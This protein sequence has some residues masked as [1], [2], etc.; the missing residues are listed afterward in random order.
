[1]SKNK[2]FIIPVIVIV[3]ICAAILCIVL[4]PSKTTQTN[5]HSPEAAVSSSVAESSPPASA[6]NAPVEYKENKIEYEYYDAVS[7][8][9]QV[10][11]VTVDE[12][13]GLKKGLELVAE[14]LFGKPLEETP[15]DPNSIVMEGDSIK[16]D[17]KTTIA[18]SALGASEEVAMLN[19]I[20]NIYLNNIDGVN[21]IYF[22]IAGEDFITG[23]MVQRKDTPY[24]PQ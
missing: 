13:A 24:Q 14:N 21:A 15:M 22:S 9:N 1:M 20:S 5:P 3:G 23:H 2:K 4:F 17:F 18:D 11:S 7:N 19:A 10:E 8:S 12:N 16:I 6:T